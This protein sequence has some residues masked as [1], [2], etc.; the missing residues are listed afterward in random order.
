MHNY[1]HLPI[2]SC[3]YK[4]RPGKVF[5]SY[6]RM[7]FGMHNSP[8]LPNFL[9]AKL[10]CYMVNKDWSEIK[11]RMQTK[12][13]LIIITFHNPFAKLFLTENFK[14]SKLFPTK[15]SHYTI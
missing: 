14:F 15:L 10:S 7:S 3:C 12:T 1:R 8:N 9:S 11:H 2:Y 13:I 4:G 5:K 6:Y